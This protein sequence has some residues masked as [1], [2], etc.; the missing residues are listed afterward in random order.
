LR[1]QLKNFRTTVQAPLTWEGLFFPQSPFA[2]V[3]L[4]FGLFP[5]KAWLCW[6]FLLI[7]PRRIIFRTKILI[8]VY[9]RSKTLY[10]KDV[11]KNE[12]K[13]FKISFSNIV[14]TLAY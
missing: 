14:K 12:Q 7:L 10:R 3:A 2:V 4:I 9:G 6:L 8:I 1:R 5:C 13:Y 11:I